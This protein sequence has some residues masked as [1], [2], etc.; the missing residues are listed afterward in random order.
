MFP[1]SIVDCARRIETLFDQPC[2]CR[3][4]IISLHRHRA[5]N[6]HKRAALTTENVNHRHPTAT[7]LHIYRTLASA[8]ASVEAAVPHVEAHLT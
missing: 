8:R 7:T 6:G 1:F 3:N 5:T 4:G 2:E